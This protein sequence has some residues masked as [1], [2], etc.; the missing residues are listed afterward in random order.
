MRNFAELRAALLDLYRKDGSRPYEEL[1]RASRGVLTH[2]T[3]ARVLSGITGRPTRHFVI[4]FAEVCG[5]RGVSLN[6]WEQAWERAEERRLGR[7]RGIVQRRS[8]IEVKRGSAGP[9][10]VYMDRVRQPDGQEAWTVTED[11]IHSV[12]KREAIATEN[13]RRWTKARTS[14]GRLVKRW[15]RYPLQ[16]PAQMA[17]PG[18]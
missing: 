3:L 7:H 6:D 15:P 8:A 16:R 17:L 14:S 13:I 5:L 10:Q 1:E 2:S 4:A 11:R 9:V 12:L 18:I